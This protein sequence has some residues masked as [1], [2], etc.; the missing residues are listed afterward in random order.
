MGIILMEMIKCV[1]NFIVSI[2]TTDPPQLMDAVFKGTD[3]VLIILILPKTIGNS[4]KIQMM[5]MVTGC[6]CLKKCVGEYII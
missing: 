2:I 4:K 5:M 1:P 6:Q 3:I